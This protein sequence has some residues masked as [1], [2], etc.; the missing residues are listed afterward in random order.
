MATV[1]TAISLDAG[2]FDQAQKAARKLGIPRSR[3]FSFALEEFLAQQT[4]RE[5]LERLNAVCD[6]LTPAGGA[7]PAGM[8]RKHRALVEGT[9]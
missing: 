7:A 9:W 4:N 2:L 8:R 6:S 5:L 1:K 3:L